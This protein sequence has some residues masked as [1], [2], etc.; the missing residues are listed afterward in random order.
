MRFFRNVAVLVAVSSLLSSCGA[1]IVKNTL[2]LP[3]R[4]VRGAAHTVGL[5][6]VGGL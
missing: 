3:G 4:A 1:P 6:G 5:G 2:S